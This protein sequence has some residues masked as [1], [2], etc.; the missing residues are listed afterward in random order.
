MSKPG[1]DHWHA[2]DWVMRYLC[3]IMSYGIYYS[4]HPT[5]MEGYNSSNWISGV[6]D[7][8]ATTSYVFTFGGGAVSCRSCKQTIFTRSTME[9][10]LTAL[11]TTIVES[12]WLR[13]LLMDLSV[14]DNLFRQSF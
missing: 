14:V 6:A 2:L 7:L 11:D 10:E 12:E 4:G 3:G 5:V 13:E 9:A 8:Y 1:T